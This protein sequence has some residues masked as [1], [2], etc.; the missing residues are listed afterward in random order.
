MNPNTDS[1][2]PLI[3]S[4]S[5]SIEQQIQEAALDAN[6][7]RMKEFQTFESQLGTL[8]SRLD[9]MY[10]TLASNLLP[11]LLRAHDEAGNSLNKFQ[12]SGEDLCLYDVV[13]H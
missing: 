1:I 9:I 4:K 5:E 2:I 11:T 8:A 12:F 13:F 10:K 6:T 7:D 3:K